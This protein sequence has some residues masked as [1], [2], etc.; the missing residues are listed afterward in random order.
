[1]ELE[2]RVQKYCQEL[3][4]VQ[5]TKEALL[6]RYF[7]EYRFLP[8]NHGIARGILSELYTLMNIEELEKNHEDV[9]KISLGSPIK[10]DRYQFL[11]RRDR[12]GNIIVQRKFDNKPIAEVDAVMLITSGETA[13]PIIVE[14]H[15]SDYGNNGSGVKAMLRRERVE[16]KTK[17][18][19]LLCSKLNNFEYL[20]PRV[21]YVV[22][23]E[24]V[25]NK[26]NP[27]TIM[28]QF[29]KQGGIIIPFHTT[30]LGW[31][32]EVHELYGEINGK[33][34]TDILEDGS[35]VSLIV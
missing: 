28:Y 30:R 26:R 1:M 34:V 31:K 5:Q 17:I 25:K 7:Q 4:C 8:E 14:S 3:G 6:Q 16:R 24:C 21:A 32:D 35:K 9:Q 27:Q 19:R 10:T 22:G 15:I 12:V 18:I 23:R 29:V 13:L 20:E 33:E 2:A 11:H